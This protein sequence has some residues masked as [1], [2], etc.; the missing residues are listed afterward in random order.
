MLFLL[1]DNQLP[2][3]KSMSVDAGDAIAKD[4]GQDGGLNVDRS[5][6]KDTYI[7]RY[8]YIDIEFY[9]LINTLYEQQF[10]YGTFYRVKLTGT[11]YPL[12]TDVY[13]ERESIKPRFAGKVLEDYE[14]VLTQR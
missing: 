4:R 8:D 7:F 10:T 6:R 3:F 1:N 5:Y 12:N 14:L 11:Q 13:I 2:L 9:N